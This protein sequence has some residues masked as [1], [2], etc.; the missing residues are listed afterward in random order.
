MVTIFAI[1]QAGG[2]IM[3][4]G[5]TAALTA[6]FVGV[7]ALGVFTG[8][9]VTERTAPDASA[10]VAVHEPA[11]APVPAPAARPAS[12]PRD[13]VG[14]TGFAAKTDRAAEFAPMKSSVGVTAPALHSRLK[15][16]LNSGADME[17]AAEGFN[18]AEQFATVAHAA[19]NTEVPFM[20]LKHRV[21]NEGDTLVAAIRK[22]KPKADAVVEVDRARAEA[23]ADLA[24]LN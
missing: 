12:K 20:L 15:P 14:T 10:A 24:Q 2:S 16:L 8:P 4:F 11:P 23:R 5:K 1:G 7:F 9:Y 17:I 22:S 13:V 3:S 19:Q 6:G 21:L 18:S